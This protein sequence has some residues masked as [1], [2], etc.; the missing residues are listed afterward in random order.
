[1]VDYVCVHNSLRRQCQVCELQE[2][3]KRK[4]GIINNLKH[5]HGQLRLRNERLKKRVKIM[6]ELLEESYESL[7]MLIKKMTEITPGRSDDK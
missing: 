7:T 5:Y 6:S 3:I 1:M 2:E 4:D